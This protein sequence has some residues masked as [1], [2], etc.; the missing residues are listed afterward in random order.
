MKRNKCGNR[1]IFNIQV[2]DDGGVCME[3][4]RRVPILDPL[5]KWLDRILLIN[6]LWISK[7]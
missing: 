1:N 6:C 7:E 3:V 5:C 2:R 4:V